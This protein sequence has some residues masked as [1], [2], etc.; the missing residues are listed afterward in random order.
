M[1]ASP[2]PYPVQGYSGRED[3]RLSNGMVRYRM[4][5]GLQSVGI[6]DWLGLGYGE[7]RGVSGYACILA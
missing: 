1:E 4:Q 6:A 5:V 3:G 7:K 2:H